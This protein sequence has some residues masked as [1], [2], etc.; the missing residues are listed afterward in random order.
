[1]PIIKLKICP[2]AGECRFKPARIEDVSVLHCEPH[3][4]SNDCR[5][6]YESCPACIDYPVVSVAE[7]RGWIDLEQNRLNKIPNL[8]ATVLME[9][10][11]YWLDAKERKI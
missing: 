2:K 6:T 3:T 10:L 8:A 5:T 9:S 7:L 1:M 11:K 4:P